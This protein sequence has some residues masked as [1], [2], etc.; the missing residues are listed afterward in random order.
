MSIVMCV[1]TLEEDGS[2]SLVIPQQQDV[3]FYATIAG[4]VLRECMDQGVTMEMVE[5][6]MNVINSGEVSDVERVP[7]PII[8]G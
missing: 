4:M 2:V 1:I 7:E 6:V 5:A 8:M 3:A